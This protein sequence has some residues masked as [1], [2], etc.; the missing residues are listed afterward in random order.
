VT[1]VPCESR[2]EWHGN[3]SFREVAA[4]ESCWRGGRKT[5]FPPSENALIVKRI[6][7]IPVVLLGLLAAC[8]AQGQTEPHP[9]TANQQ[10]PFEE[11]ISSQAQGPQRSAAQA[12]PDAPSARPH[13]ALPLGFDKTLPPSATGKVELNPN[14]M[15]ASDAM[16]GP[17]LGASVLE[18]TERPQKADAF[19]NKYMDAAQKP[20]AHYQPSSS[21]R[22]MGRATDAASR[23][24]VTRDESGKR[25]LNSQYFVRVLTSVAADSASRRYRA[26]NGSAPVSDFGSTVGDDAGMNLLHEFGPG[27]RQKVTGHMPEF[28]SRLGERIIR[29][30]N[31]K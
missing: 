27:I 12:L 23:I 18:R 2:D 19:L 13:A 5:T 20:K 10:F 3:C 17:P 1:S 28:V 16:F 15:H 11:S 31:P 21:D 30:P 8:I 9:S 14:S 26:R 24:F 4:A 29:L 6:T 22:F 7:P 25:R